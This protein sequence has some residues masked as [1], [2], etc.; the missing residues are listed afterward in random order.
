MQVIQYGLE[1]LVFQTN[2]LAF[3]IRVRIEQ[4]PKRIIVVIGGPRTGTTWTANMFG[5]IPGY[6]FAGSSLGQIQ[7]Y[8]NTKPGDVIHGHD[9][10]TEEFRTIAQEKGIRVVLL[11]R[12]F[13]DQTVSRLFHIRHNPKHPWRKYLLKLSDDEGL[14]PVLRAAIR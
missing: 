12:D 4:H 3:Q 7:L 2:K 14:R 5:T 6:R 13:R 1:E 10:F 8:R 9:H 11:M